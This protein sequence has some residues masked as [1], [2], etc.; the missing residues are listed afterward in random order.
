MCRGQSPVRGIPFM[1]PEKAGPPER[2]AGIHAGEDGVLRLAGVWKVHHLAGLERRLA[3]FSWPGG[4]TLRVDAGAVE[5]MDTAGAWLLVRTLQALRGTGREATLCGLRPEFSGLVSLVSESAG[6]DLPNEAPRR[7]GRLERIGRGTWNSIF[8]GMSALS[9]LGESQVAFFRSLAHPGRI[10][11]RTFLFNLEAGGFQALPIT[12]LLVF[13]MGVVI[14][15]QAAVQ[16]RQFGANVY[17]VDLVGISMLREISPLVTAIIVAGRSGSAYTAEIGTMV[18][19]EE[20]DA[21]RTLGISPIDLLVVPKTM[22][23]VVAL[24]LL[25]VYADF[26]GVLGG[27]VMARSQLNVGYADFLNR[28]RDAIE[29]KHYLIGVAKAPVFALII[30]LVGCYQGFRVSGGADAVGRHT[31]VSVVQSIFLVIVTDAFF[32]IVFNWAGL[33]L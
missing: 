31:T 32:S 16:L 33:G 5:G 17:I 7:T 8:A 27:M 14:A 29:L 22:A 1:T 26:M 15:Y 21:I 12:G 20:V 2:E 3:R 10:R 6:A 28:F 13:L 19:N 23:L 25:T 24:P 11:W 9:F 30:S 18:A 4:P